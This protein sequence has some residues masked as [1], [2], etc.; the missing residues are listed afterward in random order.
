[1]FV[2]VLC[3]IYSYKNKLLEDLSGRKKV[4]NLL[5]GLLHSLFFYNT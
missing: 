1:M 3:S 4:T 2:P 5:F